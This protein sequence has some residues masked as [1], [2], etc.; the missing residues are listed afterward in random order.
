M[1]R[2]TLKR[3]LAPLEAEGLLSLGDEGWRRS[4]TLAISAKG[5]AR[6]EQAFPLWREAQKR[7]RRQLGEEGWD[8][9]RRGVDRV[10]RSVE[11]PP[12]RGDRKP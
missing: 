2:S 3:N 6:L 5:R 12:Q 7:L 1:D 10:L 8:D 4:R 11:R 9:V